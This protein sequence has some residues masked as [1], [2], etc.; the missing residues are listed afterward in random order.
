MKVL[1][2]IRESFWFLPAVFGIA[3]IVL[4]E[5]LV[6]VDS[7][8]LPGLTDLPLSDALSA[9]GG[10]S[11]LTT[12]GTAMLTVAGTSFSI[13]I[14]V[15][16]TTSSTYGP[17]L[18]RNFIADRANQVVLAMFTATFL[19]CITALRSVHVEGEGVEAFV[20]ILAVHAAI[21]IGVVDVAVLV[22]FINHIASSVQITSLQ[23]RVR[24]DL[25]AALEFAYP[26]EPRAGWT[27]EPIEVAHASVPVRSAREGYVETVDWKRLAAAA[28]SAGVIVEVVA[29]PGTYVLP[30]D[31]LARIGSAGDPERALGGDASSLRRHFLIGIARTPIH[32]VSFALQQLVEVGVRGLASGTND[33]YTAV[34]ALDSAS[35]ALVPLWS[36]RRRPT[37]GLLDPHGNGVVVHWP[38][39]EQLVRSVFDPFVEYGIEQRIV[40]AAAWKLLGRLDEVSSDERRAALDPVR[41]ALA[42]AG[43]R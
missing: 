32:D 36:G 30:G 1:L 11:I 27:T 8:A 20:P 12:I 23:K 7:L 10:R 35:G 15:L 33:P 18:V 14:S 2:R 28:G 22:F 19:Y 42:T 25:S 3:A 24:D 39:I 41:A 26:V 4:A 6:A 31:V 13:T 38:A 17:R 29:M 5:A 9:S 40:Q 34:A 21:V 37:T 16:A 43:E